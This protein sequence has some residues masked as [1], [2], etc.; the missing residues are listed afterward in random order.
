MS[1]IIYSLAPD[2]EE[3][4]E[5]SSR[6]TTSVP[7]ALPT[8]KVTWEFSSRPALEESTAIEENF[9]PYPWP[10]TVERLVSQ[11]CVDTVSGEWVSWKTCFVDLYGAEYP[12]DGF[13][14]T[15]YCI[16]SIVHGRQQL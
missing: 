14:V 15:T 10:W 6:A 1:V 3:T 11:K 7:S 2:S 12:G 5:F 16:E 13:D 4:W 9:Y 8:E